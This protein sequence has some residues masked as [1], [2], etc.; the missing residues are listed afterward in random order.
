MLLNYKSVYRYPVERVLSVLPDSYRKF[1]DMLSEREKVILSEIRIRADMPCSFTVGGNNKT[2]ILN[3]KTVKSSR[4]EIR[5]IINKVCSDSVY[6]YS[7]SIS[8]GYINFY[9]ARIGVAGLSMKASAQEADFL[10]FTSINIRIPSEVINASKDITEYIKKKGINSAMGILAVSPPNCGKTTFLRALARELSRINGDFA[11]RVCLAD[12][13]GE[14][15]MDGTFDNCYCDVY[16]GVPKALCVEFAARSMSAQ[17]VILD[18]IGN[19]Q[20]AKE[21]MDASMCGVY[22]AASVHGNTM[23]DIMER[24]YMKRLIDAGVF[25]TAYFLRREYDSFYGRIVDMTRDDCV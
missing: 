3:G 5:E 22:I 25:K 24:K 16:T 19:E 12:E 2:V 21:I 14:L 1:Y 7:E 17:A 23:K 15:F 11:L 10:D 4:L 8:K 20:E 13:R 6:S 18:E 9:G